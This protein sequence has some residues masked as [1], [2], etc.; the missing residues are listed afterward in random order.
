VIAGQRAL[1]RPSTPVRARA[2]V[3]PGWSAL[4]VPMNHHYKDAGR[5]KHCRG[6]LVAAL[7]GGNHRVT[8]VK[9]QRG[10]A[11]YMKAA[12][13]STLVPPAPRPFIS[14]GR[15]SPCGNPATAYGA[16]WRRL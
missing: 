2:P 12:R 4:R 14:R 6:G 16:A 3:D 15:L 7:R 11:A 5:C 13:P 1:R 8:A 10:H 9:R